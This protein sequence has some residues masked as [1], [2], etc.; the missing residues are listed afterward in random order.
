MR[1]YHF[2]SEKW[3]LE[4]IEKQRLKV[5]R[6]DDL[7]DPFEVLAVALPNKQIRE[8]FRNWK[9]DMSQDFGVLCF[10]KSWHNPLLW[11]HYADRHKGVAL[12]FEIE[13]KYIAEV[14]YRPDR[15]MNDIENKLSS[16]SISEKDV[17][18]L[19]T[20]K[21]EQWKYEDEIR[22]FKRKSDCV[23]ESDHWFSDIG[24]GLS[25]VGI[26]K[27]PLS[28]LTRK[29]ISSCLPKGHKVQVIKAR[30]AFNSFSIVKN[31]KSGIKTITGNG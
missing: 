10:S 26:V 9:Q 1:A 30:M 27:G 29:K 11:S 28:K 17:I 31:R 16:G 15:L 8:Q 19:L 18:H 6:F 12:E 7:N 5:S 22:V 21:F 13:N 25:L 4:A 2:I 24:G 3:A 14:S 23:I 20:T